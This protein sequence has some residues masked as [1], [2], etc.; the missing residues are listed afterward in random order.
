MSDKT[1]LKG[2][3]VLDPS[4]KLDGTLDVLLADGLVVGVGKDLGA[5]ED[6]HVIDCSGLLVT[7]GLID[8]HVHLREPGQEHK[9]TIASGARSA[10][11]GGFTAICAMPNTDPA[12]DDPAA[13]AFVSAQ[14]RRA[15]A[16]RTDAG[17]AADAVTAGHGPAGRI[18]VRYR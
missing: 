5:A 10:A 6:A 14:G 12:I 3:R 2:G 18:A 17:Q 7:P 15:G 9:E 8:V 1:L 4:Q 13:V 11:A 16:A